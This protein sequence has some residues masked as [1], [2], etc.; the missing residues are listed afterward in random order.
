MET[1]NDNLS[2]QQSLDLIASM[3]NQAKGNVGRSSFYFLLWGWLIAFCNF[4][5]YIVLTFTDYGEYAPSVWLL[6]IPAWAIS[7]MYG[8]RES[9]TKMVQTHLDRISMWVWI[10]MAIV[11]TP[12]WVFGGKIN[13][14]MNAII[15]MPVGAATFLS[16]IIVRFNPLLAGG[17]VFWISG[18]ACYFVNSTDQ[19][20]I[21]GI[22][23]IFGYLVPGYMLRNQ[24]ENHA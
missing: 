11:I 18:I 7:A 23:M 12:A 22:A 8:R 2:P 9:K 4:G 19:Y 17:V 16:G 1:K 5:M 3:I 14:M 10:C 24:K 15:L 20:L 6:C 13:W 21:G